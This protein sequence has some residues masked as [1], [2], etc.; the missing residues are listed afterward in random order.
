MRWLITGAAGMVGS[1]LKHE[2]QGQAEEIVAVGR[3][4]LDVADRTAVMSLVRKTRPDFIVN[5]AAFT[6][7][8]DCETNEALASAINGHAVDTLA[9]SA[10]EV[11]AI[12][13]HISTDFVFD[14]TSRTPY[15][16]DALT[17][18]LSAYGRSKLLGEHAAARAEKHIIVRT[19]WLFGIHGWNFV[20]AIRRQIALGKRELRVVDDQRGKPTYTPHLAA[21]L[22]RLGREAVHNAAAR[23]IFHYAD[24]DE[25]TW[26]DFTR[27]IVRQ[28]EE[29]DELGQP[30]ALQ[31]VT[32]AEFPRPAQRPA[33]SVLSTSRYRQVTGC[34]AELWQEGLEEYLELRPA[35]A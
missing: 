5:C 13:M 6:K 19:S 25:C 21:A 3:V 33:Y 26:Y 16:V 24:E 11:G 4:E 15:E 22:I 17:N 12:L 18:P 28:L 23:G 2:L 9:D 35:Q 20:E 29:R 31:P 14:G 10:N 1:D 8:D 32:T 30:V 7:V 27:E 34:E